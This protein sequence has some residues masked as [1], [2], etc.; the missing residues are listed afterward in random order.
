MSPPEHAFVTF[1]AGN[2][3]GHAVAPGLT[4]G[5]D[6][7]CDVVLAGDRLA[8]RRHA[9]VEA[10]DGA[11]QL[12]DCHGQGGTFVDGRPAHRAVLAPGAVVRIGDT[13]ACLV[14]TG[15]WEPGTA[16][17][18]L[19]GGVSLA[20]VRRQVDRSGP[21]DLPVLVS[22][23]TGTGKEVVARLIHT[24]SK[25]PGPFIAANCAA[26]M[27]DA[28]DGE[29]SALLASAAGG[30]IFLD[31]VGDLPP[32]GQAALV[33]S[34]AGDV[35]IVAASSADLRRAAGLGRFRADLLAGL[36]MAEIH[37]P[38]LRARPEDIPL[39]AAYL[40]RRAGRPD[41]TLTP[42]ALEAL[43]V[44]DWP[45]NV[46]EL[47]TVIR[48]AVPTAPDELGL[49][50]LPER[51]REHLRRRRSHARPGTWAALTSSDDPQRFFVDALTS[52]AGNIRRLSRELGISRSHAYRLLERWSL[53]LSAFR[54]PG[55]PG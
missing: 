36:A 31:E 37:V 16:E 26:L 35:R 2:P 53:D 44:Y 11:V 12:E 46:R 34:L 18:P 24:A 6:P 14:A 50:D 20:A 39:L 25:R 38:A 3:R 48:G 47:E 19:V 21:T 7:G 49:D 29:L 22:G 8:F 10:V 13:L 43:L 55:A 41:L 40:A 33:G 23:E 27:D 1:A 15:E 30:T 5:S 4:V 28:A 45:H 54:A 42:D 52:C 32:R 9:R 51:I 17:G